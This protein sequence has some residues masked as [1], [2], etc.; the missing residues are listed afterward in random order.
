MDFRRIASFLLI[1]TGLS[2][3]QQSPTASH[4]QDVICTFAD[5]KGLRIEY[6]N[7]QNATQH[8]LKAHKPWTP[9]DKPFLLFLDTNVQVGSSTVPVGAYGIY[10]I[11]GKAQWE[12]VVTKNTGDVANHDPGKNVAQIMMDTGELQQG[13]TNATVYLAH[14]APQQCNVRIVYGKTMAWGEIHEK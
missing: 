3:A 1:A 13:E 2:V 9:A 12:L 7:S 10:I 5:G 14:I 8:S 6:D 11:P 4:T